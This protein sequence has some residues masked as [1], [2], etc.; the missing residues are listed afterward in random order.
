[1]AKNSTEKTFNAVVKQ[2][3]KY[4]GKH[5]EPGDKF[6]VK[7]SDVKEVS[8]YAEIEI[9]EEIQNNQGNAEDSGQQGQEA[10]E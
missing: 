1:M 10:G 9:P 8:N 4:G 6:G 7:E 2:F 3:I 5:L